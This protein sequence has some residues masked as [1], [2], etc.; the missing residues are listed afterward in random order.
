M[1]FDK[2]DPLKGERLEIM[3][4][5]GI[6]N[7]ALRPD[8]PDDRIKDLYVRMTVLREADKTALSLQR[9]GRM[10]TYAPVYGQEAA[11]ASAAFLHEQDWI[12]PSYRET[13]ALFMKGVPLKNL[14]MYWMGDERGMNMDPKL[15]VLPIDVVVGCPPL[16]A[17]GVSWA[18]K[19]KGEKSVAVGYFGDG[20]SSQ[21]SVHEAMNMAGVFKTPTVFVCQNNQFAISLPRSRQTAAH[22]IA[23]RAVGYGF[24]GIQIYGNDLLAVYA[25][26]KEATDLARKGGGPSF[27]EM[28]TYRFGPHTTADDPNKYRPADEVER[29]KPFD[30][31]V[32]LRLY[33][34]KK[35]LWSEDEEYEIIADA[36]REVG[37]ALAEAEAV[38]PP[39]PS[40]LF[41][42][43]WKDIPKQARMQKEEL[44]SFLSR[45]G[46]GGGE[47]A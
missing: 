2:F 46:K 11:Q 37:A 1:Y 6:V 24:K 15:R 21:G 29:N 47:H 4:K 35:G 12:A 14:Y 33:L 17:V 10:G 41:D 40:D 25:A 18:M 36:K 27:I 3:D 42:Y 43:T 38:P 32:R 44:L 13:G 45:A 28:L 39:S 19:L 22:T 5:D 26:M 8:L 34:D 20:A 31:L 23:Q 7:E 9:E 30:P 16:H